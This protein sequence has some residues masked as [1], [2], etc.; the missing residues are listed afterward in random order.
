MDKCWYEEY[1]LGVAMIQQ[2]HLW[3]VYAL[4]DLGHALAA[5]ERFVEAATVFE[6]GTP[7][8]LHLMADMQCHNPMCTTDKGSEN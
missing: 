1:V 7:S 6:C 5:T 4:K 2:S 3:K 8:D